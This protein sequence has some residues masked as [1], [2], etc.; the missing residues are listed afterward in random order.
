MVPK[1]EIAQHLTQGK[2]EKG[3]KGTTDYL[4]FTAFCSLP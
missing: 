1:P 3:E 4:L 2:R